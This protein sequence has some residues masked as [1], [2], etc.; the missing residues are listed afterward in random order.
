MVKLIELDLDGNNISDLFPLSNLLDLMVLDLHDNKISNISPLSGLM[1][2]MVLD[3]RNNM[4]SNF[5]PISHL[6]PNLTEYHNSNQSVPIINSSDVNRDG[7]VNILDLAL[8]ALYYRKT[9]FG[10][11]AQYGT[12]PDVNGDGVV[13]IKDLVAVAAAIDASPAAP[14]INSNT[15]ETSHLNANNLKQWIQLAKQLNTQD[16]YTKKGIAF[17]HQLLVAYSNIDMIPNLTALFANYPN[18]FNPETWIPF[19]LAEPTNVT[20]SIF[21]TNGMLVRKIALG[22]LPAGIYQNKTKAVKWD[23]KNEDGEYVSSG[24]YYIKFTAGEFIATSKMLLLK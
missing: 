5:S 10:N 11:A 8:V 13:D 1:N 4:I 21:S 12:Y 17:L 20:V 16:L 3:I 24:L 6:I 7:V 19:Q 2:L 18:P 22:H 9:D 23:G 14:T 15:S